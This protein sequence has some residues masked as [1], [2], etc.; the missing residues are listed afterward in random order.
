MSTSSSSTKKPVNTPSNL[1]SEIFY[2]IF[3]EG[4]EPSPEVLR[5]YGIV[6]FEKN[7]K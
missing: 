5:Q 7:S 2:T 4:K 1:S 3:V 6:K